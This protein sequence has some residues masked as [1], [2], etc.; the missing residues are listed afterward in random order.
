MLPKTQRGLTASD[1][2]S[3]YRTGGKIETR[4]FR[5]FFKKTEGQPQFGVVVSKKISKS[6][7]IRNRIK[8]IAY[9]KISETYDNISKIDVVLVAKPPAA[10]TTRDQ[11]ELDLEKGLKNEG[12]N[13]I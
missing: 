12:I 6:A 7:V 13:K 3:F 5:I 4:F 9:N 11:L 8:R 1:F 2:K 10:E